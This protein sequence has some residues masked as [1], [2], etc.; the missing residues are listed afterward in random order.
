MSITGARPPDVADTPR[1]PRGVAKHHN[2]S[3]LQQ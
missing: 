3:R 1:A 2:Q